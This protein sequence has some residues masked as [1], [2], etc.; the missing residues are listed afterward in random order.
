MHKYAFGVPVLPGK[1]AHA[2]PRM[3]AADMNGYRTSRARMGVA[4]ER[5]YLMPTPMGEFAIVYIEAEKDFVAGTIAIATSDVPADVKFRDLLK[6]I[7]GFDFNAPPPGPP[8]ELIAD[9]ADPDVHVRKPGWAFMA[10][11][12]PG[13]TDA[14]RAFAKEAWQT[15]HADFTESR[16]KLGGTRETVFLNSTPQ[17]DAVVVYVEADDPAE[18]NRRFA[19]SREPFDVWFKDECSKIFPEFIDFNEPL[20]PIETMWDQQLAPASV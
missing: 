12:K 2:P 3:F 6:D 17:G 15:R 5:I 11:L 4:L 19:A 10:P 7:H 16:R 18:T 13:A 20:P 8:P 1:D 14:G 9:W